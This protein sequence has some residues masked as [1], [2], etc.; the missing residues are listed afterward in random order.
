MKSKRIVGLALVGGGIFLFFLFSFFWML[1]GMAFIVIGYRLSALCF[2]DKII[3][4]I[5]RR[6]R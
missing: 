1:L 4:C 2:G 3:S 5:E 6:V